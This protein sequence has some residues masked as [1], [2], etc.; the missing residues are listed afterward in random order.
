MNILQKYTERVNRY[1]SKYVWSVI[2]KNKI[3]RPVDNLMNTVG[4][5]VFCRMKLK[6]T[7]ILES[8]NDFDSNGGAF[9]DYL[10]SNGFNHKY[11]IVWLL[12]NKK[13][14]TLPFNVEC[15]NL[16]VPSIRKT[17]HLCTAKYILFCHERLERQ[18][19]DQISVY[20]THGPVGLKAF[21]GTEVL[22]ETLSYCLM[23]SQFL[24]PVLSAEYMID[25]SDTKTIILGYPM[26]DCLYSD[27]KGE[28]LKCSD[29]HYEKVI[30]WMPTF[31]KAVGFHRNDSEIDQPLGIPLINTIEELEEVNS[32]LK[33]GNA[34]L[35]I[36][37]HPMQDP[38]TIKIQDMSNIT[39]LDGNRVKS[40]GI[41]NYRLMKDTDAI[42]SDYSTVA[43]D[44]LH[45]DRPIGYSFDDLNSYSKGLLFSD[46]DSMLAGKKIYNLSDFFD[47][48]D[49]VIA[50]KDEYKE[51]RHELFDKVFQYHDGNSCERLA[52]FLE[53]TR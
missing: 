13:P 53:L 30:L 21:K 27:Q 7:I 43:Y 34:L 24:L 15:F 42:L 32:K 48:I 4:R 51:K 17:F 49:D 35:I 22:P 12:R 41:D 45:L 25:K 26:H 3:Y 2:L 40:L 11:K 44:Y 38:T 8:H 28:L 46:V 52:A 1:G 47:F 14:E 5:F 36:K 37:L 6:D 9:Y 50:G 18:R 20:L 39:V 29:K 16:F 33:K 31:R 10:I 19:D 23:P